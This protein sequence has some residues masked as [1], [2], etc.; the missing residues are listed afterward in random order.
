MPTELRHNRP[1]FDFPEKGYHKYV[2]RH[3][4]NLS[5]VAETEKGKCNLLAGHEAC[6]W[7]EQ[8]RPDTPDRWLSSYV[9]IS[10]AGCNELKAGA[11]HYCA[12][13]DI[14]SNLGL[15]SLKIL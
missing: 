2:E 1:H 8:S 9:A 4:T 7:I 10:F 3:Y 5:V 13:I 14:G 11:P 12:A 6:S 15:V